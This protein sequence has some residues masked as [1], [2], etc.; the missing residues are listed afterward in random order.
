MKFY[1]KRAIANKAIAISAFRK[2][3]RFTNIFAMTIL[4]CR[5]QARTFNVMIITN[6]IRKSSFFWSDFS[7][8]CHRLA[9][10]VKPCRLG[11]WQGTW[12]KN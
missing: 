8:R 2:Y 10:G 4:C 9:K 5:Q 12:Q 1:V 6:Q 3:Q 11:D 7:N